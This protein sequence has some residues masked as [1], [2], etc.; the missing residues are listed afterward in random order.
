MASDQPAIKL[1]P[2]NKLWSASAFWKMHSGRWAL[3]YPG[4]LA[5][6]TA[7]TT[8]D[9]ECRSSGSSW[10]TTDHAGWLWLQTFIISSLAPSVQYRREATSQFFP[11]FTANPKAPS[12]PA[13]KLPGQTVLLN[14]CI[15]FGRVPGLPWHTFRIERSS[16]CKQRKLA[17]FTLPTVSFNHYLLCF[18]CI[19]Q[20]HR[21]SFS[22]ISDPLGSE[23]FQRES[24]ACSN[25]HSLEPDEQMVYSE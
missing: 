13:A 12:F 6:H 11:P 10:T 22:S 25:S 21:G 9:R 20:V 8:G 23:G 24:C 3:L 4:Q 17:T 5:S 16:C 2:Q 19:N 7:C 1:P 18:V 15:F 14:Y